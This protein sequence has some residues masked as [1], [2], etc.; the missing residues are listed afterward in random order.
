MGSL[1]VDQY[2]A[3]PLIDRRLCAIVGI[4]PEKRVSV[5]EPWGSS[6]RRRGHEI[7]VAMPTFR[8]RLG[9]QAD[10]PLWWLCD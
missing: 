7:T 4:T 1:S 8:Y 6:P 2:K 5:R 10:A 9:L 3:K